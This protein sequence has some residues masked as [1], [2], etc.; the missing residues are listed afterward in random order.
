MGRIRTTLDKP[1]RAEEVTRALRDL[2]VAGELKPRE[3][4]QEQ[5][6]AE[7]LGVSRTPVHES[8]KTLAGEGLV[9]YEPHCGFMVRDLDTSDVV[10][11]FDVRMVLEGHAARTVAERGLDDD[12]AAVLERNLARSEAVLHGARWTERLQAEWFTLNWQFH[13]AILARA[14]NPY[15]TR[16]VTQVRNL[17]KIYDQALGWHLRQDLVRLYRREQSQQALA[18]HRAVFQALVARQ[19]ERAEFLLRD[20]IFCNREAML[21]N[22]E[23]RVQ[24]R[25]DAGG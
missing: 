6:L 14:A 2:I 10:H 17:P 12:T 5:M 16:A 7:R 11:A 19:P 21:R 4:L 9:V 1:T 15:L 18:D 23:E 13:D 24:A 3:R 22:F 20:H 8:L 25:R